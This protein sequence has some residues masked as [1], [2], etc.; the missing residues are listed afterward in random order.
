M[1]TDVISG[2][3]SKFTVQKNRQISESLFAVDQC[4]E[5]CAM[6]ISSAKAKISHTSEIITHFVISSRLKHTISRQA[7]PLF[8][9]SAV[10]SW[11]NLLLK[12]IYYGQLIYAK[13]RCLY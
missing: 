2:F 13:S 5:S 11:T 6:N 9:L 7:R 4:N 10:V 3:S 8:K 12:F 1:K